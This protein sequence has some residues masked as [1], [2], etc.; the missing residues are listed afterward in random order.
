MKIE[1][2]KTNLN[3]E[4]EKTN[5][6]IPKKKRRGRT[7][8]Q[9]G[10][11]EI[12]PLKLYFHLSNTPE[13]I[14]MILGTIGSIISGISGPISSLL[15]GRTIN[16]T[17]Q[18]QNI[19]ELNSVEYNLIMKELKSNIEKKVNLFLYF[20]ILAFFG[21]FLMTFMWAY[22]ALRQLHNLKQKYFSVIL[23]QEQSWFDQ[24]NAY[25]FST[26]VQAQIEQIELGVGA[27]FGLILELV[28][29]II[30]GLIISFSTSWKLTLVLICVV[31]FLVYVTYLMTKVLK[32]LVILSR[33]TYEKA[34]GV[35]E[36][37]L[38]NIK[39]VASFANFDFELERFG[40]LIEQVNEYNKE[41]AY[42]MGLCI[43]TGV[44]LQNII[45]VAVILYGKKLIIDKEINSNTGEP[46][47]GGDVLTVV[48]SSLMAIHSIGSVSSNLKI[49]QEAAI[50]S[51]DYFF[52]IERKPQ[53]DYSE[54][55]L[56][57]KNVE[58]R[59]E[60]KNVDFL[61]PKSKKKI[62]DDFSLTIQPGK[63][64]AIVGESGCGKSTTVNLIER[65]YETDSGEILLDG[66][67]IKK[68]D[69]QYLRSLIGYVQQEPV[70]FNT[71][72]KENIIF[73]RKKLLEKISNEDGKSEDEII[74]DVCKE[75]H[76]LE[77]INKNHEKFNYVVGIK[78][79][80]LSGGQKQRIAIAR[81]IL[82]KPKILILDEATS[83]LDN[84]SEKEVQKALDS[85]SS[86]NVTTVII[87]HRLST[88]INS[89]EI[90]VMKNGKIV[91]H[92]THDY[93]LNLN[94]YYTSLVKSQ[95][96]GQKHDEKEENMKYK[97][98]SSF[99]DEKNNFISRK[100]DE[101]SQN[102]GVP[103]RFIF[104]LLSDNLFQTFL[105]PLGGFVQGV[106]ATMTGFVLAKA[107]NALSSKDED[108]I[109]KKGLLWGM[110]YLVVTVV[111]FFA[112]FIKLWGLDSTGSYI[113]T[114]MRKI[115][116][117][118]Y[119]E[120]H[121]SFY[122]YDQN[123]PG[124]LITR[125]TIDTTQL[126]AV[127]LTIIGDIV[128]CFG[129]LIIGLVL[130]FYYE[131]RLTLIACCFIPFTVTAQLL[132]NRAQRGGRDNDKIMNIEAGSILSECVIN[133]KTIFSFNFQEHAVKMYLN[134]IEREV[135]TFLS[136]SFLQ[137][138]LL[139]IGIFCM[140]ASNATIFHFSGEYISNG[141]IDFRD[142]NI[143][144]NISI[145]MTRGL[146]NGLRGI[147]DYAKAKKSL[148][149]CYKVIK[150]KS[151]IPPFEEQNKDKIP[152]NDNLK[153]KIEFK[154]VSF[155]Y[156]TKPNN[157]ILKNI[158]FKIEPG[159]AAALV[160][161]SGCGKSTIIQLL[162]RFYDI[163]QGEILIDDI[164]IKNYNLYQLRKKIGLV[165]Q[166]PVLFKRSVYD[167]ILY[168]NL[169]AEKDE[170]FNAAK[171]AKIEKFFNDEEMGTKEDPVSG[172]E[173]Q[174]LAIARAF[175]KNPVILL[176]DEA[177]S[178]LDKESEINV[179]KS[180]DELQKG[181]TSITVAHRLSTIVN[182]DVIFVLENG[183]LVEQGTHNELIEKK[184]K[185]FNLYKYSEK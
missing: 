149:S 152:V 37:L 105:G 151:E 131:Y 98:K 19:Y 178:A 109:N 76:A 137:G 166:E 134:V 2:T 161:F 54:S 172:G 47:N 1:E 18:S 24:N 42:K 122:D 22:S 165:S 68:Y 6:N 39:T 121:M 35:M 91:E 33:K 89:D 142:M 85:I 124:A 119:L 94:G 62:L 65:L 177:T 184:G 70:L 185:Y 96:T 72:I 103:F 157:L 31:P 7:P 106:A 107:I 162:E 111:M 116:I 38:Y 25:E 100:N 138:L 71:S 171:N 126:S 133:T 66:I 8:L 41:K 57:P 69:I 21:N 163:N 141:T 135:K 87:A 77:F 75:A 118:K 104:S 144:I 63:K 28:S 168:G 182:S 16:D 136:D 173:K 114:K 158:S 113:T 30:A 115:V 55:V 52:L 80:K 27:K 127:V 150:I 92:G 17:T 108:T 112:L 14:L 132:V 176:L 169:K 45:Y 29:Q 117:K 10:E 46:F 180:I 43:G 164:N 167:N 36:E 99:Q 125:L 50:A 5:P 78:G 140:F 15:L 3:Q 32:R 143:V 145:S 83:A 84:K 48:T 147:A 156:P 170:V 120:M 26:K 40:K 102:E 129:V 81:A 59:I 101:I 53:I 51:S 23:K 159:K 123:S 44:F 13:I 174:R 86:K 20:G 183:V 11:R 95:L 93:L 12:S 73:G 175:L 155:S 64:I 58:G 67:D 88:I 146:A 179:Q 160:G 9:F 110:I 56:K 90:Y 79:S 148:I 74:N 60:F 61:Y 128:S 34:G 97:K 139:G 181:R 49:I 153:G 130:G 82:C 4:K 154:N